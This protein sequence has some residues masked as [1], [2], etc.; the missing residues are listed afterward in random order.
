[1]FAGTWVDLQCKG[2]CTVLRALFIRAQ[3]WGNGRGPFAYV[4]YDA[5]EGVGGYYI[6]IFYHHVYK[7]IH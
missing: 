2:N 7:I 6:H 4:W 3:I 1:M 5:G